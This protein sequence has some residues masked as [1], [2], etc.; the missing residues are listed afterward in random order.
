M[1]D[2][3]SG[4]KHSISYHFGHR[5]C[6]G[7]RRASIQRRTKGK[8]TIAGA[9]SPPF[10]SLSFSVSCWK[11]I[12]QCGIPGCRLSASCP[13]LGELGAGA[14][15]LVSAVPLD[16]GHRGSSRVWTPSA[17]ERTETPP[18]EQHGGGREESEREGGR[19]G[20]MDGWRG[21]EDWGTPP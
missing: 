17:S 3:I 2:L 19:E 1:I 14:G 21:G 15:R 13:S 10:L 4:G 16:G 11:I 18:D 12:K 9:S 5:G 8:S 20:G 7:D 6:S